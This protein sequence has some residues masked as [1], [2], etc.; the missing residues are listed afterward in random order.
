MRKSILNFD[1]N[2]KVVSRGNTL[3]GIQNI[4]FLTECGLYKI[5]AKSNKPIAKNFKIGW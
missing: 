1:E 2:D 5:I 4:T 3:G